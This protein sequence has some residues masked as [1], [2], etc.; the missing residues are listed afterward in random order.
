VFKWEPKGIWVSGRKWEGHKVCVASL[1]IGFPLWFAIFWS[2][3]LSLLTSCMSAC[4]CED[5]YKKKTKTKLSL[6]PQ[7]QEGT[8]SWVD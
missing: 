5:K 3:N 8:T 4:S 1:S 7:Q 2:L 6:H